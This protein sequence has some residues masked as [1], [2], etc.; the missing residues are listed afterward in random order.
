MCNGQPLRRRSGHCTRCAQPLAGVAYMVRALVALEHSRSG[1]QTTAVCPSCLTAKEQAWPWYEAP[2][3][4]C[5]MLLRHNWER[6]GFNERIMNREP[7][8]CSDRCRQRVRRQRLRN[9]AP[10]ICATCGHPFSPTRRDALTCSPACRQRAYRRRAA[11]QQEPR[12]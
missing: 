10:I 5:S 3:C 2:C 11:G 1:T 9:N 7:A 6:H 4:G 12:P 8:F